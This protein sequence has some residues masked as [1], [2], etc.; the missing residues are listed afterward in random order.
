MR[1]VLKSPRWL[2]PRNGDS[3]EGW[4]GKWVIGVAQMEVS[5]I[6]LTSH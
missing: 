6:T 4:E 2:V 3:H 1:C 5:F